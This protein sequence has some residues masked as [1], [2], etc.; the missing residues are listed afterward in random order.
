MPFVRHCLA[1]LPVNVALFRSIWQYPRSI[2]LRNQKE[3]SDLP[4]ACGYCVS[5]GARN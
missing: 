3:Y 5:G 1:F 4:S 2:P